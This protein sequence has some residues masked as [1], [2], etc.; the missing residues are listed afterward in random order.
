MRQS[1]GF[2]TMIMHK[3]MRMRKM[4]AKDLKERKQKLYLKGTVTLIW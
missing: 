4:E 3:D 2:I 1:S